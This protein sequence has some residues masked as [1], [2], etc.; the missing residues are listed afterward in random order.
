MAESTQLNF[1]SSERREMIS[2]YKSVDQFDH[3]GQNADLFFQS[4]NKDFTLL[5]NWRSSYLLLSV[6]HNR[7]NRIKSFYFEYMNMNRA[8]TEK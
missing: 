2:V 5:E 1:I 3:Q 4:S 7:L 6:C 8:N